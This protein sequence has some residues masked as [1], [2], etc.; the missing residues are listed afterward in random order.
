MA[1]LIRSNRKA[2]QTMAL[3][4]AGFGPIVIEVQASREL[5][6]RAFGIPF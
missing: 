6:S 2:M 1:P 4:I 3:F 5:Y